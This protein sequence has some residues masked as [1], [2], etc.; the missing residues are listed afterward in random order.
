MSVGCTTLRA[1]NIEIP[2]FVLKLSG[3]FKPRYLVFQ[4]EVRGAANTPTVLQADVFYTRSR[5]VK[6]ANTADGRNRVKIGEYMFGKRKP[7][8]PMNL[9]TDTR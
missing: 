5:A 4:S 1:M 9:P 2:L 6:A 7:S 3:F 8:L